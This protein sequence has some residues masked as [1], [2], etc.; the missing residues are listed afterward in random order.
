MS[1]PEAWVELV[2]AGIEH[3]TRVYLVIV[4][5]EGQETRYEI[6]DVMAARVECKPGRPDY[7]MPLI[8]LELHGRV[9]VRSK[10]NTHDNSVE[11]LLAEIA[12]GKLTKV[13][14]PRYVTCICPNSLVSDPSFDHTS[15]GVD[16]VPRCPLY[17]EI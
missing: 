14:E 5:A 15:P 1:K 10:I 17:C 2:S 8:Q 7:G 4:D 11:D 16:H 13:D 9:M 12:A 3:V 6:P